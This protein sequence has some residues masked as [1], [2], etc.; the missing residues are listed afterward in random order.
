MLADAKASGFAKEAAT[1]DPFTNG[2]VVGLA[3]VAGIK[4]IPA[5]Q[6]V[7]STAVMNGFQ[8]INNLDTMDLSP[9][10][11]FGPKLRV[12][13]LGVRPYTWDA[14]AKK[15]KAVGNYSDYTPDLSGEWLPPESKYVLQK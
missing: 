6:K 15:I 5:G 1:N 13:V 4:N 8:K 9:P 7:D 10:V 12:G 11:S 2:Y 14:T 3:T